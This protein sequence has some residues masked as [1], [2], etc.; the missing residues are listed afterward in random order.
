[1][2]L[3]V[4]K[5]ALL[6]LLLFA[7]TAVAATDLP[8]KFDPTRN[9]AED[10][11]TAVTEAKAQGK[12]VLVD[13][14]GEWCVWCHILDKFMDSNADVRSERD[15]GYVV[16]KVNWSPDNKNT[17]VLSRWPKI[18]GY[19]HLFVLDEAGRLIHSQDTGA[20]EA[21]KTYDQDKMLGFFRKFAPR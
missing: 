17:E 19:P 13:V 5:T 11:A 12:R 16:V 6:A 9:A 15:A 14:G 2:P 3:S 20:L 10:V 21:G 8:A 18:K 7:S 1:M 4:L